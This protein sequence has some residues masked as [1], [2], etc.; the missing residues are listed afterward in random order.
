MPTASDAAA[1]AAIADL[2]IRVIRVTG[3]AFCMVDLSTSV[4]G[5]ML[6]ASCNAYGLPQPVCLNCGARMKANHTSVLNTR[7]Q[8]S[9]SA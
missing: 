4:T 3:T 6:C 9:Q 7:A 8:F 5:A 2:E 1:I